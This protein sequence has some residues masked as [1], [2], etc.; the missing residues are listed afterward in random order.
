TLQARIQ[1]L[2]ARG[3]DPASD[4]VQRL[5]RE[6]NALQLKAAL[7]ELRDGGFKNLSDFAR[8]VLELNGIL[9]N[10]TDDVE[11]FA[12]KL[13]EL[14]S[15]TGSVIAAGL[16]KIV[17][18]IT[19]IAEAGSDAEEIVKGLTLAL[20]GAAQIVQALESGDAFTFAR[21]AVGLVGEGIGMLTGIPGLGQLATAA[22][23]FGA[24]IVQA[25]SD[26]FTGDS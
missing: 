13:A 25:I 9:P 10:A 19:Q 3:F 2:I 1:S 24:M 6:I 12:D 15:A 14:G 23:D 21:S 18:G 11:T 26:A 8:Q 20:Q 17:D 5:V 22:F 4:A 16:A 7:E